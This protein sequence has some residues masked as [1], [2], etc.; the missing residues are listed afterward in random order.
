[1]SISGATA[2]IFALNGGGTGAQS[3][4][5]ALQD[6]APRVGWSVLQ[7]SPSSSIAQRRRR[8]SAKGHTATVSVRNGGIGAQSLAHGVQRAVDSVDDFEQLQ[9]PPS[10]STAQNWSLP[11]ASGANAVVVV[12]N[13]G[14]RGVHLFVHFVQ[15][16]VGEVSDI[17]QLQIAPPLSTAQNWRR[18]SDKGAT[19]I[20]SAL[21]GGA[22]LAQS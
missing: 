19:V 4:V 11:S 12:R 2:I 6:D 13:E 21:N 16:D 18:L 3:F 22:D 10:S 9:M 1:L 5:Q 8:L 20:C 17:Q 15:S 7:I 14:R